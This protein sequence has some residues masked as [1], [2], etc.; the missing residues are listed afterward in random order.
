MLGT[1]VCYHHGGKSK[2]APKKNKNAVTTGQFE[3]LFP[4][5]F[6]P[7]EQARMESMETDALVVVEEEIK[8]A[9]IREGRILQRLAKAGKAEEKAGTP[10]GEKSRDGRD[11]LHPA[12]LPTSSTVRTSNAGEERSTVVNERTVTSE[13]HAAFIVRLENALTNVQ[14]QI[15]RL[16]EQRERLK[17]AA[18]SAAGG[19]PVVFSLNLGGNDGA[20]NE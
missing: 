5:C 20:G 15:S 12:M 6:T 2:G 7:E 14:V 10:T 4:E 3:K 17:A 16:I 9:R 1:N 13:T 8:I 18:E 19:R 11:I